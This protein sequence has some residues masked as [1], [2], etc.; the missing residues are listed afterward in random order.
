MAGR[1]VGARQY[2]SRGV[3]TSSGCLLTSRWREQP[4]SP[5]VFTLTGG[6][7]L[8]LQLRGHCQWLS[9]I[10]VVRH[11][12]K[13]LMKSSILILSA[14]FIVAG[15]EVPVPSSV[16]LQ[17]AERDRPAES[18]ESR[19]KP[20]VT[21]APLGQTNTAGYA[22]YY[23]SEGNQYA[24]TISYADLARCPKWDPM[25]Q[26]N[27][28][29][30]AAKALKQA[31]NFMARFPVPFAHAHEVPAT[32]TLEDLGLVRLGEDWVWRASY[33]LKRGSVAISSSPIRCWVLMDG[34]L[35][36]PKAT[37][38]QHFPGNVGF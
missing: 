23:Y 31:G 27:P 25:T 17:A 22:Y 29:Y 14:F 13:T 34:S 2:W 18:A 15:L 12:R 21:Y 9:L 3:D 6:R 38:E 4:P 20:K 10:V 36:Q 33:V 1:A 28:P 8:W 16:T 19:D 37:G 26:D 32:W 5:A 7:S 24:V 11:S 30:P 35:M